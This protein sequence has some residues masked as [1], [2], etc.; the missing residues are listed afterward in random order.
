M[1]LDAAATAIGDLVFGER[2]QKAG[3]RPALLV[4][5]CG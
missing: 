3:G 2:G 1:P 4:R 5:T